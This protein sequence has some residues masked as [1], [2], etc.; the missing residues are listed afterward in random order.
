V[1]RVPKVPRVPEVPANGHAGSPV[2]AGGFG[3]L[4]SGLNR[5]DSWHPP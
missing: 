5:R 1:P 3:L 2:D 4:K